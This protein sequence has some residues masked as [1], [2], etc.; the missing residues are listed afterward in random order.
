MSHN[1]QNGK[2]GTELDS[3]PLKRLKW[4]FD[5]GVSL[6]K[7]LLVLVVKKTVKS[8]MNMIAPSSF[9][10]G[11]ES[12]TKNEVLYYG[13]KK[14]ESRECAHYMYMFIVTYFLLFFRSQAI[15]SYTTMHF[16]QSLGA[17]VA[18]TFLGGVEAAICHCR[19]PSATRLPGTMDNLK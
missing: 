14:Q 12:I 4:C 9:L 6:T 5:L 13:R 2:M 18:P 16:V 11:W 19:Q 17:N 15:V 10:F 3:C 1:V 8:R 7:T